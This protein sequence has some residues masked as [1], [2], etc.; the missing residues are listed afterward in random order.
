MKG[1]MNGRSSNI[2]SRLSKR[3]SWYPSKMMFL[4]FSVTNKLSLIDL[5]KTFTPGLSHAS[6]F[7]SAPMVAATG[8]KMVTVSSRDPK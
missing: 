7:I 5:R 6:S 4:T 1:L 3:G 8:F 2:F